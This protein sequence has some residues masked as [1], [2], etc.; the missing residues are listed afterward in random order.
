MSVTSTRLHGGT[1]ADGVA[2]WDF[3]TNSNACGPCPDS[4]LALQ[5]VDAAHYPDPQY[6]A[7]RLSLARFHGIDVERIVLAASASEAIHRL[8]AWVFR[9]GGQTYYQPVHAFSEYAHAAA[10][11]RL[12][13]VDSVAAADLAW[14]CDPSSPLGQPDPAWIEP[15]PHTTV[16]VD[17]AYAPL[18]L[19]TNGLPFCASQVD[20]AVWQLYSPNK[21]LGLTGVRG[22]YLI[23]PRAADAAAK[24]L[25]ALAPSW[26]LGAHGVALLHSWTQA[27]TQHWLHA[28]LDVLRG[29]TRRQSEVLQTM[30]WQ[31]HSSVTP[32]GCARP[33]QHQEPAALGAYLRRRGIKLRDAASFGLPGW[34]RMRTLPPNGQDALAQAWHERLA[35][36]VAE[37]ITT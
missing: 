11:W 34:W 8:S 4:L 30:G 36:T 6:R 9:R 12:R 31:V 32:Y 35:S 3:S 14:V 33:L 10:Q 25:D 29:W 1:D 16:V 23:A 26:V 2:Q 15:T 22:A 17:R 13:P 27:G 37:D 21:A 20:G 19:D 28:S 5:Q 24:E 7:L 18:R